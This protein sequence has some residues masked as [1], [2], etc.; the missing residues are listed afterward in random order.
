M[1]AFDALSFWREADFSG[2]MG[3]Y[4]EVAANRL[5]AKFR[6]CAALPA[7]VALE[8]PEEDLWRALQAGTE[9]FLGAAPRWLPQHQL[10]GR[11]S[12]D[13]PAYHPRGDR[14]S[15]G[16]AARQAGSRSRARHQGRL[17]RRILRQ[18]RECDV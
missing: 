15:A 11:G 14:A 8:A 4:R 5:P 12:D 17:V 1:T 7:G 6:I 13:S 16:A 10:G 3:W 9:D 2:C 18:A